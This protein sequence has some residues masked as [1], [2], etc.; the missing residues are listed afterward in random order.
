LSTQ[1]REKRGEKKR[2]RIPLFQKKK[3]KC[4]SSMA[5]VLRN[6]EDL[7]FVGCVSPLERVKKKGRTLPRRV[8]DGTDSGRGGKKREQITSVPD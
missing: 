7:R 6:L 8:A 4:G 1:R 3:K 5:S 2:E